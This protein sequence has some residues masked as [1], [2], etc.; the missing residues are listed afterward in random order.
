MITQNAIWI[1]S[2]KWQ[3]IDYLVKQKGYKE[4]RLKKMKLNQLHAIYYRVRQE[5]R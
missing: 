1:P 3:L 2:N 4:W 5:Q